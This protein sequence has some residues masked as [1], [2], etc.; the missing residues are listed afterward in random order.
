MSRG[1]VPRVGHG[2]RRESAGV[3]RRR[4][5][6]T[7]WERWDPHLGR[8]AGTCS[9]SRAVCTCACAGKLVS[10]TG[11]EAQPAT[12]NACP[13]DRLPIIIIRASIRAYVL[14]TRK[15]HESTNVQSDPP[16][17]KINTQ[18]PTTPHCTANV[19]IFVLRHELGADHELGAHPTPHCAYF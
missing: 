17:P 12:S 14:V 16:R 7:T 19:S 9:V 13:P 4:W 10:G 3:E 15:Q 1:C 2:A 18:R 8:A 11:G 5:P 6:V